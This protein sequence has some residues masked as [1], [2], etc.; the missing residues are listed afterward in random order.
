M[1]YI[2][3]EYRTIEGEPICRALT[4]VRLCPMPDGTVD[5]IPVDYE[6]DGSS[7]PR[8]FQGA[9]PKW[10]HPIASVLH[11]WGCEHSTDSPEDRKWHDD[12]FQD[13]V[14]STSWWLTKKVG[15]L[16]V[17]TGAFMRF[18]FKF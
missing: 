7:V 13:N 15:W 2:P 11:D 8:L 16:G 14:G 12:K 6:W 5:E 10:R 18:K 1:T 3:L 9:F 4:K 17:R